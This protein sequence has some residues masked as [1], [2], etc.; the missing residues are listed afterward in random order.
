M[1]VCVWVGVCGWVRVCAC[2]SVCGCVCGGVCVWEC[3][4]VFGFW[5]GGGRGGLCVCVLVFLDWRRQVG[6]G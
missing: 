4:G 3:V 5:R 6:G 2:E 1:F